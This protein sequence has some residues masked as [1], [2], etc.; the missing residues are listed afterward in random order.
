MMDS[1]VSSAENKSLAVFIYPKV[2]F[3]SG[4][5]R[6]LRGPAYTLEVIFYVLFYL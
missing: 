3:L 6:I 2:L 5:K 1:A 4:P